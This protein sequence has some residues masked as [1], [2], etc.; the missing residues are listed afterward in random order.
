MSNPTSWLQG[1][2]SNR[3]F[4][5]GAVVVLLI[6][7]TSPGEIITLRADCKCSYSVGS[8][9][10]DA[11]AECCVVVGSPIPQNRPVYLALGWERITK[12]P[13]GEILIY[14]DTAAE[15][16]L[17]KAFVNTSEGVRLIDGTLTH[18][19]KVAAAGYLYDFAQGPAYSPTG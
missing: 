5:I 18:E 10:P 12:L 19:G 14:H 2:P 7:A 8:P 15:G 16:M 1:V 6:A 11:S 3:W 17:V 4:G 13:T 9:E